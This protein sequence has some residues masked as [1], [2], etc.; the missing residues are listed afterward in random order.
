MTNEGDSFHLRNL[1]RNSDEPIAPNH[2][3]KS[4]EINAGIAASLPVNKE[5]LSDI[6]IIRQELNIPEFNNL[7]DAWD[8]FL[9]EMPESKK[10]RFNSSI[11]AIL[12]SYKLPLNFMKWVAEWTLFGK[13]P[14]WKPLFNNDSF[15][16]L[17]KQLEGGF[18]LSTQE[19]RFL[20]REIRK[21][22]KNVLGGKGLPDKY[23]KV[24]SLIDAA[25]NTRRKLKNLPQDL[26]IINEAGK[27][28]RAKEK[29]HIGYLGA[30]VKKQNLSEEQLRKLEKL[31][32]Q[33]VK[34]LSRYTSKHMAMKV[35]LGKKK[36]KDSYFRK[37]VQRFKT[38]VKKV[39]N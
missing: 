27:I 10:L 8:W 7:L 33:G 11:F 30:L 22:H 19:K 15:E 39:V 16:Y 31:N 18:P 38:R 20:K 6:R 9:Y 3:H 12:N 26:K 29:Q 21:I 28:R 1:L 37:R 25:K 2:W 4:G 36:S 32:P 23:K 14:E 17:E 5:F 13:A 34:T 35:G 24:S